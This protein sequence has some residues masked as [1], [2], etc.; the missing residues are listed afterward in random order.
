MNRRILLLLVLV[1]TSSVLVWA[2]GRQESALSYPGIEGRIKVYL[3][4]PADMLDKLE[5]LFEEERGDV[6]EFVHM[7]C[8]PLRQ[9]IW[10][11]MESGM[12]NADVLWGSDPLIYMALNERGKL[13]EYRPKGYENLKEEFQTEAGYTYV[14][15]R[16]GVVIY[17]SDS[18]SG[19]PSAFRDLLKEEYKGNICH[20]DPAFSSTALALVSGLWNLDGENGVFYG[21]L[22]ENGLFLTKTNS[23]VPS[24]IQEGEYLAGIAPHDAVLRLQKKAKKDGYP[25]PLAICWPV[26]GAVAIQRPIAIS[27]NENRPQINEEIAEAFVDFMISKKAQNITNQFGFVSVRKDLPLPSGIPEDLK[28]ILPDWKHLGETQNIINEDFKKFFY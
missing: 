15:E 2:E 21:R 22:R 27:K 19:K 10:A 3:S 14:N 11:E 8:G 23:D 20:A 7:G 17:N 25:T 28:T 9:R 1:I 24:K 12:I 26:E 16:Y 18:V 4:G 13:E 5:G 6:L